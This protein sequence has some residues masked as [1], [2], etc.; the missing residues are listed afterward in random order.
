MSNKYCIYKRS[1]GD[2]E[3][4]EYID[5]LEEA[6]SYWYV[7]MAIDKY[8]VEDTMPICMN[9]CGGYHS[10][11]EPECIAIIESDTW[12]SLSSHYDLFRSIVNNKNFNYGWIDPLGNTYMCQ[13]MGHAS[14]ATELV[15]INYPNEWTKYKT[16]E[17]SYNNPDDFL[18]NKGWIKV[19][20]GDPA[21][22]YYDKYTSTEALQKLLEVENN[23]VRVSNG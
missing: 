18:L 15:T 4:W 12:P 10:F 8:G 22:I 23:K 5:D 13:Y 9:K 19:M 1:D 16:S 7:S 17:D 20:T 6:M 3:C 14:L 2:I 11:Y 21:H